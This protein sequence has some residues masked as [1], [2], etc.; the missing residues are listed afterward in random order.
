M[1]IAKAEKTNE[2]ARQIVRQLAIVV[3]IFAPTMKT[4][5]FAM[6]TVDDVVIQS[7]PETKMQLV[8]RP[9]VP[10]LV[11]M[12]FAK[13]AKKF[14]ALKIVVVVPALCRLTAMM[15][16]AAGRLEQI[17]STQSLVAVQI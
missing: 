9:I 12:V 15:V 8:V 11:V 7:V 17:V 3:I 6:K 10:L 2:T 4:L 5:T 14:I 1:V 13:P 16:R